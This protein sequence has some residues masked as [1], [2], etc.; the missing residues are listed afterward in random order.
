MV[1]CTSSSAV[2][3][4]SHFRS[5][6]ALGAVVPLPRRLPACAGPVRLSGLDRSCVLAPLAQR[7]GV[8]GTVCG[9]VTN[10][11]WGRGSG[12]DGGSAL[13]PHWICTGSALRS[14]RVRLLP[15]PARPTAP[16]AP[17]ARGTE[18]P[19]GTLKDRKGH[20]SL[21]HYY[22]NA[23]C[24]SS[25]WFLICFYNSSCVLSGGLFGA[26]SRFS[27]YQSTNFL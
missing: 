3:C 14:S 17:T 16:S 8:H 18:S 26:V 23:F 6:G 21:Q 2:L 9:G 11:D 20:C 27:F 15:I 12:Q 1:L 7:S 4:L 5:A 13:D 10:G 25:V 19:P 24:S 22:F